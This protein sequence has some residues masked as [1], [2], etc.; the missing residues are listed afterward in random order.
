MNCHTSQFAQAALVPEVALC[1]SDAARNCAGE[2]SF[3][4]RSRGEESWRELPSYWSFDYVWFTLSCW[5]SHASYLDY[6]D[7]L[8]GSIIS[9][10]LIDLEWSLRRSNWALLLPYRYNSDLCA[11]GN[12]SGLFS[13][14]RVAPSCGQIEAT[15]RENWSLYIFVCQVFPRGKW[16]VGSNLDCHGIL[17]A[18]L[19]GASV[20]PNAILWCPWLLG[21]RRG[22]WG[23][24][25][26]VVCSAHF[27][28]SSD[29]EETWAMFKISK[30]AC[31]IMYLYIFLG[32]D[33]WFAYVHPAD[34]PNI[35]KYIQIYPHM[36]KCAVHF[37]SH[38]IWFER[39]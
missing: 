24:R 8:V 19:A 36:P 23:S 15:R 2:I 27:F 29:N 13:T 38:F 6:P 20:G 33:L 5:F 4:S 1:S 25:S 17:M 10:T 9:I 39:Y 31:I 22:F 3:W 37:V 34:S 16:G 11:S 32:Q 21:S 7:Y 14:L 30:W 28:A 12:K 35:S 18:G 26:S